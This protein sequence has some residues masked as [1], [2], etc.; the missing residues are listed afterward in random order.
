MW[1]FVSVSWVK[2]WNNIVQDVAEF[3]F[4]AQLQLKK[5]HK[6]AN[7]LGHFYFDT[8]NFNFDFILAKFS[9]CFDLNRF[10]LVELQILIEKKFCYSQFIKLEAG[11]LLYFSLTAFKKI[12]ISQSVLWLK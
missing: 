1:S 11:N 9:L 2:E 7:Y 3:R 5:T 10:G 4:L 8:K 12:S 6:I